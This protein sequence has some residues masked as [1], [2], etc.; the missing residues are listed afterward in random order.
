MNPLIFVILIIMVIFTIYHF[1]QDISDFWNTGGTFAE[2]MTNKGNPIKIVSASQAKTSHNG[3]ASRIVRAL[4]FTGWNDRW[5]GGKCTHTDPSSWLK[6]VL[7]GR[8]A[9]KEVQLLNRRDC[10][11]ERLKNAKV[12]V[13]DGEKKHL[14]GTVDVPYDTHHTSNTGWFTVKCPAEA[15]G[16]TIEVSTEDTGK[17]LTLCGMKVFGVAAPMDAG[18]GN[19]ELNQPL[20]NA[21]PAD[22]KIQV[23]PNVQGNT[24]ATAITT[25][26]LGNTRTTTTTEEKSIDANTGAQIQKK[27]ISVADLNSASKWVDHLFGTLGETKCANKDKV[28]AAKVASK[29]DFI[30]GVIKGYQN[31]RNGSNE[32]YMQAITKAKPFLDQ[33]FSG[34]KV[35]GTENNLA[36]ST[37]ES[38]SNN[39]SDTQAPVTNNI[40]SPEQPVWQDQQMAQQFSQQDTQIPQQQQQPQMINGQ[41]L[42][43]GFIVQK[44][45]GSCPNGCK[46]PQYDNKS[47]EDTVFDGKPYRK[48]PWVKDGLNG[49]DCASCGAILMP[50]NEHGYART[51]PGLFDNVSVE[52][53]IKNSEPSEQSPK[54][55]YYNIGKNF[56]VQLSKIKN[57]NL[58]NTIDTN[59]FISVGKLVHKYQTEK[60][61][62]TKHLLTQFINGILVTTSLSKNQNVQHNALISVDVAKSGGNFDID[63]K[64]LTGKGANAFIET[65]KELKSNNRLGGSSSLYEKRISEKDRRGNG[66]PRDP[67]KNPQPYNSIWNIFNY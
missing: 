39:S 17:H 43:N 34:D 11:S 52:M 23:V 35:K 51:A 44:G 14:C 19:I 31:D 29:M 50:K 56:M 59:E 9:V 33:A 6:A 61:P 3:V 27:C 8:Y 62:N 57:F 48:C 30:S 58:P 53:A 22:T 64:K 5:P 54:G 60:S 20:K 36:Q 32:Y 16:N 10:C 1:W 47:C 49:E 55:D 67:R 28:D 41:I 2:G 13:L 7:D 24:T 25:D 63:H 26:N 46:F 21:Y 12:Y 4:D 38:I 42:P 65:E 15:V 18:S 40:Q 37:T 66:I 45:N